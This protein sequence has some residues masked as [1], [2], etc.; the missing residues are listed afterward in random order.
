MT[1]FD[2]S[3]Y[4]VKSI[5]SSNLPVGGMTNKSNK[6]SSDS[7][8]DNKSADGSHR[9]TDLDHSPATSVSFPSHQ[10][11]STA[12]LSFGTSEFWSG[13]GYH[14]TTSLNN[15]AKAIPLFQNSHHHPN[16]TAT[17]QC[18]TPAQFNLDLP[19]TH[20][21]I[22]GYFGTGGYYQIG[23]NIN[24]ATATASST[25]S[26]GGVPLVT[27]IGLNSNGT[28]TSSPY[29]GATSYGNWIS[30]SLHSFQPAKPNLSVFQTPIFGME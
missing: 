12:T 2:I 24:G 27:R 23:D 25:T 17:L 26:E 8:S 3:R 29:D 14:N 5:A 10:P 11:S 15:C 30:P 9:S 22:D 6:S 19:A 21:S 1:N 4:D 7:L 20:S 16:G 28:G 13:L 18:T